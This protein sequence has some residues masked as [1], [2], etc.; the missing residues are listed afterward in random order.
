M[1]SNEKEHYVN[2]CFD[3]VE[4]L[5]FN[6][7]DLTNEQLV[8]S[9]LEFL[10]KELDPHI[11]DLENQDDKFW[12]SYLSDNKYAFFFVNSIIANYIKNPDLGLRNEL[13]DSIILKAA[14]KGHVVSQ[15]Y[16][17]NWGDY[18]F[19]TFKD[20]HKSFDK[21]SFTKSILFNRPID[22]INLTF[23]LLESDWYEGQENYKKYINFNTTQLTKREKWKYFFRMNAYTYDFED[24]AFFRLFNEQ[25]EFLNTINYSERKI[26]GGELG[27]YINTIYFLIN[28]DKGREAKKII[29]TL[30]KKLNIR[31]TAQFY[32]IGKKNIYSLNESP[33]TSFEEI[34]TFVLN[35]HANEA[36]DM[37]P[38]KFLKEREKFIE[39]IL[40]DIDE[41]LDGDETIL[42]AWFSDT[43]YRLSFFN[44][45]LQAED[46]FVKAFELY[47][48]NEDPIRPDDIQEPINLA[49]CFIR[50]GDSS[51][52]DIY[53]N[54]AIKN[55][56]KNKAIKKD[57]YHAK[58]QS[59]IISSQ[60][61]MNNNSD[62]YKTFLRLSDFLK[63]NGEN[64]SPFTR[65]DDF[66]YFINDYM[67]QYSYF[68]QIGFATGNILSPIELKLIYKNIDSFNKLEQIKVKESDDSLNN[69]KNSLITNKSDIRA[70]EAIFEETFSEESVTKLELLYAN[71]KSI[72]QEILKNR[73]VGNLFNSTLDQYTKTIN[74]L[75]SDEVILH[76]T[77]D[78]HRASVI[79]HTKD[80]TIIR[81]VN[82]K[83]RDIIN[84]IAKIRSSIENLKIDF[85]FYESNF[86]YKNIY[87]PI[88]DVLQDKKNIFLYGS[89]LEEIPFG[90]LVSDY[91]TSNTI[92]EYQRLIE[93]KWLIDKHSFARIY[94][95]NIPKNFVYEN[96]FLGIANP[97]S[98][99]DLNLPSLPNSID[100]IREISLASQ[101]FDNGNILINS[102]ASKDNLYEKVTNTFERI[103]FAT[104]TVPSGWMGLTN[105]TG[106]VLADS[107]G[108]FL[109]TP[110]EIINLNFNSDIVL[111]SSCN[112]EN[113]GIGEL[114]KSFLVAGANSVIY[115]NWTLETVSAEN[116][117]KST[118][119][120]MLF[121]S[122]SKHEA[123]RQ[124]SLEIMNDYS[125]RIYAHPAFWGNFSIAYRSL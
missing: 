66:R 78:S 65:A 5:Q 37:N 114:Y 52:G 35:A 50:N 81:F 46:Y 38:S 27:S 75:D 99:D 13:Y 103:V 83:E 94:P 122:L 85:S 23:E 54:L 49:D 39:Q 18:F 25:L 60:I 112:S 12:N 118:F 64:I 8:N 100:E 107:D 33:I 111:L 97:N 116:F 102:Y 106:I 120:N 80:E 119:K 19:D 84:S 22:V 44:L 87:A 96:K 90:I 53:T 108:D 76:Y 104:H 41:R 55:L 93:T 70:E 32:Q 109:L 88:A 77:L 62:A 24:D 72:I 20:I 79:V 121:E 47:E 51:K 42:M 56:T 34:E 86:L 73:T 40:N 29:E 48:K 113:D 17:I 6:F 26:L 30:Y 45:C 89:E 82:V 2:L 57:F 69:L 31:D 124:A 67:Y 11:L 63:R 58:I 4:K 117:T 61:L 105:E 74:S 10:N 123:M 91:S 21:Y 36:I 28:Q 125:K 92:S 43:G 7:S 1:K 16:V 115:S 14:L 3:P 71:Q 110:T 98:F 68:N 9:C 59:Q 15:Q 95:L 101:N